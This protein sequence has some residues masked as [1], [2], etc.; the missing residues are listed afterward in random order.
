MSFHSLSHYKLYYQK[1]ADHIG[2]HQ[3]AGRCH[4][5]LYQILHQQDT[6]MSSVEMAVQEIMDC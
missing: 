5:Q 4:C 6:P 1:E 3:E 2:G